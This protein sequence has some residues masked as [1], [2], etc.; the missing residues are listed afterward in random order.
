[1]ID[2]R[3]PDEERDEHECEECGER[4]TGLDHVEAAWLCDRCARLLDAR[5][6]AIKDEW[7]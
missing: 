1:M 7:W 5:R 2:E 6:E 3:D 4:P